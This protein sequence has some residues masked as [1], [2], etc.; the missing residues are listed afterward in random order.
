[1]LSPSSLSSILLAVPLA[2]FAYHFFRGDR[3][4]A[5]TLL[6][7]Y[8]FLSGVVILTKFVLK[9]PRPAGAETHFD[10]YS[11]PSYHTAFA[12]LLF[13]IVPNV[14]SLFYVA[15]MGYLRV[16][17]GVHTWIDVFGG[18][19]FAGISWW[20]YRRGKERV[21][22]EWDRQAFHMGTGALLGLLLYKSWQLGLVL[23]ILALV[24]GWIFYHQ[25]KHPWIAAFLNF[26]DRDGT[27]KGAFIFIMGSAIATALNPSLGWV[28]V[29]YLAYVDAV[30]TMV[31]KYFRTKRKSWYGT[32]AGLLMGFLV[33]IAT[34]TPLWFA[35][36]VSA[37][38]LFS[39]VDDNLTIP[40]TVAILG[41]LV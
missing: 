12:S 27:G 7:A 17:A 34:N 3:K 29:W 35:P 5:L 15:L 31:G 39:P 13:F 2:Y 4:K 40:V 32:I 6:S 9:V 10:P 21:G 36:V 26:F 25:R 19:L 30:A 8:L 33:A 28:A 41:W 14:I 38:E 22:F 18:F 23:M 24:V 20:L 37:V 1:M 16:A 11:F